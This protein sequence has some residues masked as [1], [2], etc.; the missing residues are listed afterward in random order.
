MKIP[1]LIDCMSQPEQQKALAYLRL[2]EKL[3]VQRVA[4]GVK[5]TAEIAKMAEENKIEAIKKLNNTQKCGL[6]VAKEAVD[7][8]LNSIDKG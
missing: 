8:Y 4:Q 5:H 2:L 1:N 3:E 7:F 6:R